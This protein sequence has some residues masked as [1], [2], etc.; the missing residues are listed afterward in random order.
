MHTEPLYR[1]IYKRYQLGPASHMTHIENLSS[2]VQNSE[3][4]SYNLMAQTTYQKL[5]N[6]DV[7]GGRAGKTIEVTKKPLHDYVPLYFGHKTPMVAW[8]Q[9]RND[10]FVFIR[11]SLNILESGNVVIADGNARSTATRFQIYT[12]LSDLDLLDPLAIN[13]VKYAHDADL[14]RRKQAEI[15]VLDRLPLTNLVDI[16]CF[17]EEQRAR[18]LEILKQY[19]KNFKTQ[20]LPGSWYFTTRPTKGGA[21]P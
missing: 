4:R 19:G 17:S 20:V 6:T 15:L 2:I 7:Q 11:F 16:I 14:K 13:T 18:A 5:S 10:Q 3:I 12:Q 1:Q 21:T 8:N 9:S